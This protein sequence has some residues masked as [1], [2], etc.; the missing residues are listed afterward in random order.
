MLKRIAIN[1]FGRIGRAALKVIMETQELEMIAVNDLMHVE[2]AAYL[3]RH[4]SV[5]G[6]Y[7]KDVSI[8]GDH[9]HVWRKE[10]TISF[11]EESR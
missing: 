9:L 4:D 3:L 8:H 5:C 6:K 7:D 2:N 1:G 11:A 10:D